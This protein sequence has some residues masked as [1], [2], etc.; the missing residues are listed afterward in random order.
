[1]RKSKPSIALGDG[2]CQVCLWSKR[3]RATEIKKCQ[4]LE[5][6]M[7]KQSRTSLRL[8]FKAIGQWIKDLNQ[9]SGPCPHRDCHRNMKELVVKVVLSVSTT[10]SK[11]SGRRLCV[12]HLQIHSW[13]TV[14]N[15]LNVWMRTRNA[16]FFLGL[17]LFSFCYNF[18]WEILD[19]ST[20]FMFHGAL[21]YA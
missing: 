19:S 12:I 9:Y 1:M 7:S 20:V 8:K 4:N 11:D 13:S 16:Q 21:A 5:D 18:Q 10:E 15:L 6:L 14:L 17:C 3:G 2:R